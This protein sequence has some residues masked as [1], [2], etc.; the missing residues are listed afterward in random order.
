MKMQ[1]WV[2]TPAFNSTNVKFEY[3][4]WM[5]Y[6][7]FFDRNLIADKTSKIL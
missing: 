7:R 5:Q 3:I 2:A 4:G 1:E 6:A